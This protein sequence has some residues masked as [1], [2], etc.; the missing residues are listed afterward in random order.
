[1][2]PTLNRVKGTKIES[3][4]TS[5]R[6]EINFCKNPDGYVIHAGNKSD[7]CHEIPDGYFLADDWFEH[8]NISN[9]RKALVENPLAK[10]PRFIHKETLKSDYPL[11]ESV[12]KTEELL[13]LLRM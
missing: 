13:E 2:D 3:R 10:D 7:F 5:Q 8:S 12:K 6:S 9:M 11:S 4:R 1:M